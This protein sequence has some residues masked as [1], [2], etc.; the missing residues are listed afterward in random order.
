LLLTGGLFAACE[1]VSLDEIEPETG[2]TEVAVED[3]SFS[4][5]VIEVP[6]GT[7]VTWQWNGSRDHN[8]AV[9]GSRSP[10]QSSGS[11]VH[12]FNAPGTY[13]YLCELHGGMT[14]RIVVK[15]D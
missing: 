7:E 2:V 5:R 1:S 4:P 6:A 15:E 3:N 12:M 8:V 14:G 13:N 10:T 11:F 9:D